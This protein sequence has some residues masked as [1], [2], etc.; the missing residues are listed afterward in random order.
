[1]RVSNLGAAD[2][3]VCQHHALGGEGAIE[4]ATAVIKASETKASF[5]FLYD[6]NLPIKVRCDAPSP[7]TRVSCVF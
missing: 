3:V 6:L 2:A 4:L 1:M 7:A 5:K